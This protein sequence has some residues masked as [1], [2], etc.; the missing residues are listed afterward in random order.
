V[1]QDNQGFYIIHK[2]YKP[3]YKYNLDEILKFHPK[4]EK[5]KIL[6]QMDNFLTGFNQKSIFLLHFKCLDVEKLIEGF[7]LSKKRE[8]IKNAKEII[9][10]LDTS[11]YEPEAKE[12]IK[13]LNEKSMQN[14]NSYSLKRN[15]RRNQF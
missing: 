8:Y 3:Q 4:K 11:K 10:G 12:T 1:R 13:Q 7:S 2:K 15:E 14:D 9:T 6:S 5:E